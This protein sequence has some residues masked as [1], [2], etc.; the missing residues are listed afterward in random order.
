[1]IEHEKKMME[2]KGK[3]EEMIKKSRRFNEAIDY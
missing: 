3:M 2:K 1:M